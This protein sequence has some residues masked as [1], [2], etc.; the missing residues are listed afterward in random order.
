MLKE[1]MV[2]VGKP[3]STGVKQL[4]VHASWHGFK[5]GAQQGG[6]ASLAC[7]PFIYVLKS[8]E[9]WRDTKSKKKKPKG[10]GNTTQK[11]R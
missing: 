8:E 11:G 9:G 4:A 1:Y 10:G 2:G 6:L 7:P 3:D 5:T